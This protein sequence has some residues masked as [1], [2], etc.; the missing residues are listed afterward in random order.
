MS[1]TFTRKGSNVII[2]IGDEIFSVPS[3]SVI[4]PSRR[5][6]DTIIVSDQYDE[7]NEDSGI[8]I[9]MNYVQGITF[10]SRNELIE[11]LSD[12]FFF[13]SIVSNSIGGLMVKLLNK[14]VAPSIKG[15]TLSA[16]TSTDN[17][18]Q[19]C[20]A[21]ADN[22]IGVF[23]DEGV[24]DG[25]L[26]WVVVSGIADILIEDNVAVLPGYHIYQ[27]GVNGR[28]GATANVNTTRHWGEMGH[29]LQTVTA[30][31]NK[32]VRTIMHFN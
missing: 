10:S 28:A 9:D 4:K 6:D 26:A 27:G 32:L 31:T 15:Q 25:Q 19:R 18:V 1:T 13:S 29:S 20:P 3:M 21:N 30:G 11:K 24:E 2:S 12:N 16:S 22:P 7:N 14:T 23:F 8:R 17:A 5:D